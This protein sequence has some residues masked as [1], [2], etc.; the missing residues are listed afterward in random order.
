ALASEAVLFGE[1]PGAFVVSG[2]HDA[3][4]AFG[5]A[6]TILG[7]A[8]GDELRLGG[9]HGLLAVPVEELAREHADGLARLLH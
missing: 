4:A 2:T 3:F 6:A 5:A 8:G 1:G 9:R 7:T